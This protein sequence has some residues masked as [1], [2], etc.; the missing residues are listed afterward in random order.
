MKKKR[1]KQTIQDYPP[2]LRGLTNNRF[3]GHQNVQLR[4]Y[5]GNTFGAATRGRTFSKEEIKDW[6]EK[7]GFSVA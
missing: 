7:H 6:A 2:E 1:E 5:R 3:G 4:G